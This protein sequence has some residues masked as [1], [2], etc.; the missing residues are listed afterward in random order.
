MYLLLS[1]V[2]YYQLIFRDLPLYLLNDSCIFWMKVDSPFRQ[3]PFR[4][5]FFFTS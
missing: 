1:V 4:I 2:L 5:M 3:V